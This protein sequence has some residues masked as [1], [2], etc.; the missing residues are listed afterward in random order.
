MGCREDFSRLCECGANALVFDTE[1]ARCGE[2]LQHSSWSPWPGVR[3]HVR[4]ALRAGVITAVI[5]GAP[6]AFFLTRYARR[7]EVQPWKLGARIDALATNEPPDWQE[8]RVLARQLVDMNAENERGWYM[9]ALSGRRLGYDSRLA[10][11]EARE[12]LRHAPHMGEAHLLLA[13]ELA[14]LGEYADARAH[15]AR[16]MEW[17][18]APAEAWWLAGE[19]ELART[20]PDVEL[21]LA[22]FES[23]RRRGFESV[24]LDV[25]SALLR[26]RLVGV[27]APERYPPEL[28]VALRRARA[29]L[30][31]APAG[32]AAA[33]LAEWFAAELEL[34]EGHYQEAERLWE[35]GLRQLQTPDAR[36]LIR[37]RLLSTKGRVEISRRRD[38][39]AVGAFREALAASTDPEIVG[40]IVEVLS[41]AG[42]A[43]V[44]PDLLA[45]VRPSDDERGV[46]RAA[47]AETERRAGR[48]DEALRLAGESL[49]ASPES[50]DRLILLGDVLLDRGEIE[51]AREAYER[52]AASGGDALPGAIRAAMVDLAL[53]PDA[54]EDVVARL[55]A[56]REEHGP[57]AAL[58]AAIG[59]TLLA[60]GRADEA[61]STLERVAAKM[62]WSA[63][64]WLELAEAWRLSTAPESTERSA[65]CAAEGTR[66]A[67]FDRDVVLSGA[68]AMARNG[69][70]GDVVLATTIYLERSPDD[71]HVLGARADA[72][73]RMGDW[74]SAV[75][76]L[77]AMR[78]LGT[79][80]LVVRLQLADAYVRC[81]RDED[82]WAL[83]ESARD[84]AERRALEVVL[85]SHTTR[86]RPSGAELTSP[87]A[88]AIALARNGEPS[89]ALQ[90][91]RDALSH[92]RRDAMPVRA[93]V[94]LLCT[95][96]IPDST[97]EGRLREASSL[98]EALGDAG[99][100]GLRA[101]LDGRIRLARGDATSAVEPLHAA[102]EALP[103]DPTVRFFLAEALFAVDDGTARDVYVRALW[104]PGG[105]AAYG[106]AIAERLYTLATDEPSAVRE[107]LLRESLRAD[108]GLVPAALA[109][110]DLLYVRGS[111][112]ES[113]EIVERAV[114]VVIGDDRRTTEAEVILRKRALAARMETGEAELAARHLDALER[115]GGSI[116]RRQTVR[117]LLALRRNQTE[118]AL[119]LFR[120]AL[121]TDADDRLAALGLAESL[122]RS[123]AIDAALQFVRDR[124]GERPSEAPLARVVTRSLVRAGR[125]DA[126]VSV[127]ADTAARAPTDVESI[128]QHV[129]TL[130]LVGRGDEALAVARGAAAAA[131]DS[132]DA[133]VRS[134]DGHFDALAAECLLQ[135]NDRAEEALAAARAVVADPTVTGSARL[136]ARM[137]EAESLARLD[138]LDDANDVARALTAGWVGDRPANPDDGRLEPRVRFVLGM[139]AFRRGRLD[140]A[141]A[142]F[143]RAVELDP[144]HHAA[145]NNAA[146]CIVQS[147]TSSPV[148]LDLARR[149][150]AAQPRL[151]N[152]W[153]TRARCELGAGLWDEALESWRTSDRLLVAASAPG[154]ERAEVLLRI[155]ELLL[156]ADRQG[157]ARE[158]AKLLLAVAPD[159]RFAARARAIAERD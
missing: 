155:A 141:A 67:P 69:D 102:A 50:A 79:D 93:L 158:A 38:E 88:Q 75:R 72:L 26:Q 139:I 57:D 62:P 28:T 33:G 47:L 60:A 53:S 65:A 153:D 118:Q 35:I 6:V 147:G 1:C 114:T 154:I 86:A 156:D 106:A 99:G 31:R 129:W 10:I 37:A 29:S 20:R 23:A 39:V 5:V 21:A 91:L 55:S 112:R 25:R 138:R 68:R 117:G 15:I 131:R 137:V 144:V 101:L 51:H 135:L 124:I 66:M 36:S 73:A 127:T 110:F 96:D 159:S 145:A 152:Y 83:V 4:R 128:R 9:L 78:A 27:V 82:A 140:D 52:A 84:D 71:A 122:V 126:A 150:T 45:G 77:Q 123:G 115:L 103:W 41:R 113:A 12:A 14:Q 85:A 56:L 120:D 130:G 148:A 63:A 104:L 89:R 151:A 90:V 92:N 149:A 116:E 97:L 43:D 80:G 8:I 64:A 134:E 13:T 95:E 74:A 119:A 76:D 133:A 105:K 46:V 136:A 16:A 157:E 18:L 107:R 42:R 49:A 111:F 22:Y 7:A 121:A 87:T 70:D 109:L 32:A 132:S 143:M 58:D 108:P 19:L 142:E 2:S 125:L 30:E 34:A 3:R 81:G 17:S 11:R 44:I 54:A 94:L 24:E 61:A 48:L 40:T 100:R 146:W 59:H 98:L